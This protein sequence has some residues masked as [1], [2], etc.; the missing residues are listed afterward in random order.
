MAQALEKLMCSVNGISE[1][2]FTEYLV[3]KGMIRMKTG[4]YTG[5]AAAT[6]AV[7]GV[8]FTPKF[9]M[10]YQQVDSK[11]FTFKTDQDTT[12]AVVDQG[13]SSSL[14]YV[15]DQIISFDTDGFTVGDGT[16]SANYCNLNAVSYGYIAL[17]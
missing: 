2:E 8:G 10:I 11:N 13:N 17:G 14:R 15:A 16:G 3:L 7:T 5:D 12:K 6:K 4:K 9:L 1:S